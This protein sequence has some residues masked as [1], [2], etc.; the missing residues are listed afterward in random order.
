MTRLF[1]RILSLLTALT[2][3][4][5]LTAYAETAEAA[6]KKATVMI[7]MCGTDLESDNGQATGCLSEIIQSRFNTEEINVLVLAGGARRWRSGY[8]NKELTLLNVSGRRPQVI[9]TFPLASMGEAETLSSF[10]AYCY[11][12]YPAE[13]FILNLWDHGGGPILGLMQDQ[14]FGG[15]GLYTA[16]LVAALENSPFKEEPL[17]LVML[18][19][20]LMSSAEMGIALAPYADYMVA[21]EDSF[22][23]FSY[24]WLS[25]MENDATIVDTA[26]RIVDGTYTSNGDIIAR[27]NAIE[28]NAISL[29]DLSRMDEVVTA[30]DVYFPQ[31]AAKLDKVTF[32]QMSAKR[33]D[34]ATFGIAESGGFSN[35]DLVDLGDLVAKTQEYAPEDAQALLASLENA[36]VHFRTDDENCTGLTV[37]HPFTNKTSLENFI[38]IYNELDFSREYINYVHRFASLLTDTPLAMWTDLNTNR[39][40]A[41]KAERTLFTLAL[42]EEQSAHYGASRFEALLRHEDNTYTLAAV[43][44]KTALQD[45]SLTGEYQGVAL[46]AVGADGAA[47]TPAIDYSVLDN[48]VYAI[49]ATLTNQGE[50]GA[51]DS[52]CQA[53]VYCTYDPET[54][55]L[56]PG[57]VY[58]WDEAMNAYTGARSMA[59]TD[60]EQVTLTFEHRQETRDENGTLL[61]FDQWE[62]AHTQEW[63]SAIDGN[64]H[65]Q[66][67]EDALDTTSLYAT[68]CITDSQNNLYNSDLVVISSPVA[69]A[70]VTTITY[71]DRMFTIDQC[72]IALD[73]EQ[74]ML[75]LSITNTAKQEIIYQLSNAIVDAAA[76]EAF[77]EI[78]GSGDN[79]GLM[80]GENVNAMVAIPLPVKDASPASVTFDLVCLDAATNEAIDAIPVTVHP[81]LQAAAQ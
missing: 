5:G 27:Q 20:C 4:L 46:F 19:A 31:V 12:N 40:R 41:E 39:H 57:R 45:G 62:L 15:D 7:F 74:V 32:S 61:P 28:K 65:F 66:M 50:E 72:T 21:S 48:G 43:S 14:L 51:E 30:M 24:D 42:T 63:S 69:A 35:Y 80:P 68:F 78:Y 6:P 59:F 77:A 52:T 1:Q 13:Q 67:V 26:K 58:L 9:T 75:T 23:G 73:S 3:F 37:Y 11:E 79:W 53:L 70:G 29:I 33:R 71:D 18:H 64:W 10:L 44:N 81:G 22:Y 34:S 49:P 16:E 36:V 54:R 55:Q 25:G 47:L 60:Y 38:S 8:S 76:V 17:D 56:T 2:L